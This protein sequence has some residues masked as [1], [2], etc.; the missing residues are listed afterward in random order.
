MK[1]VPLLA[2]SLTLAG[3]FV[4][5][6]NSNSGSEE[7]EFRTGT[8][9]VFQNASVETKIARM[10]YKKIAPPPAPKPKAQLV[11]QAA[12]SKQGDPYVWGAKG[13]NQF[14]CSGLT[15]WAWKQAGV[16]LGPDTYSQVAQ[17][18]PVAPNDVQPGD[19]I[20][21]SSHHVQLAISRTEVVEAPGRGMRVRI[22]SLP[23]SFVARRIA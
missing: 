10:D 2:S 3:M 12:L 17:G 4:S 14:D 6:V 20:F 22:V 8:M 23:T 21:P 15:Q 7:N 16:N 11:V 9:K 5:L 19:L 18:I 1:A 13:P